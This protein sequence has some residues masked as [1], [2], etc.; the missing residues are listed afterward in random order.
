VAS[1]LDTTT[2]VTN[3]VDNSIQSPKKFTL[4]QNYPNPF[5]AGTN[6]SYSLTKDIHI[7]LSV[8]N[9]VGEKVAVLDSGKKSAG[10]YMVF[11]DGKNSKGY[12]LPSGLYLYRLD[13]GEFKSMKKM[14]LIK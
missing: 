8:Y 7:Q 13:A 3:G 6:I 11:W 4:E 9:I 10:N 1:L 12:S 5:N 2:D 14:F